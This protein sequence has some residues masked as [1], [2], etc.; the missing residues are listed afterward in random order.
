MQYPTHW[1]MAF[2][3]AFF[4]HLTA[5]LM[6]SLI[7]PHLQAKSVAAPDSAQAIEWENVDVATE[8]KIEQPV[9]APLPPPEPKEEK[10]PEPVK[11]EQP[12]AEQEETTPILAE[13]D[14][15]VIAK[16]QELAEEPEKLDKVV[17]VKEPA[18]SVPVQ[19]GQPPKLITDYYP[20]SANVQ[21][22]GRVSVFATIGKDGKI[23]K[24]K[25]AVTSGKPEVDQLAM[26]AAQRWTFKAALDQ[27]GRPM[28]CTKIISIP[29]N[30]I[31]KK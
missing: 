29:F 15:P 1:R 2:L 25:I 3:L 24:T 13:Q 21:F 30:V 8:E 6:G 17:I 5:W 7:L 31:K 10:P 16:L 22:R 28:E 9:A 20:P 11:P 27:N 4:F 18:D 12:P 14:E 26:E 23:I 19:M